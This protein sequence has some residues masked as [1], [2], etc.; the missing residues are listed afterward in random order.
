MTAHYTPT[1]DEPETEE[2][3]FQRARAKALAE[4]DRRCGEAEAFATA[5]RTSADL[6]REESYTRIAGELRV[7]LENLQASFR[8]YVDHLNSVRQVALGS[9]R[10][11]RRSTLP[12]LPSELLPSND[13]GSQMAA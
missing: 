2:V 12:P 1:S 13:I 4:L 11:T 3:E 9:K 6:R 7:E 8:T 5:R 10:R